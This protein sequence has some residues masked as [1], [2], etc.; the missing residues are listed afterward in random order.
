[1]DFS[2]FIQKR[3]NTGYSEKLLVEHFSLFFQKYFQITNI[4]ALLNKKA[5]I[6]NFVILPLKIGHYFNI[7]CNWNGGLS[8]KQGVVPNLI[9]YARII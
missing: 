2:F 5:E 6:Q 3:K 9:N 4:F 8:L 1:L 7:D